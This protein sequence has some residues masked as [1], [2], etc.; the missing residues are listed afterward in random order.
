MVPTARL[1]DRYRLIERLGAG[2][3]SVV[4]RAYDEVL[5]RPVAVKMLNGRYAAD[6][7]SPKLIRAEARSAGRLSHPNVTNVYDYGEALET[8]GTRVPFVV[9]ELVDGVTLDAHLERGPL[10][11]KAAVRIAAEVAAALAA[12]HA[13]GLVHRDI[14]PANIMLTA[15]GVKVVDFGIAA[16]AGAHADNSPTVLGTPAYLAPERLL[17]SAVT[18]ASDVYALGLLLYRALTGRL[19]WLADTVT[20]MVNAHCYTEPAALPPIPDLPAEVGELCDRCLAKSPDDRPSAAEAAATLAAA[21]G[22]RVPLPLGEVLDWAGDESGTV[23]VAGGEGTIRTEPPVPEDETGYDAAGPRRSRS[24]VAAIALG[25]VMV[26]TAAGLATGAWS[27]FGGSASSGH[28]QPPA[29]AAEQLQ[30]GGA[31]TPCE[32]RYRTKSD[33][34]GAFAVDVTIVNGNQR[35]LPDWTLRF[36]FAGDQAVTGGTGAQWTQS[37][38]AVT[39]H[40][41]APLAAGATTTVSFTGG[42][43]AGNPLPTAFTLNGTSCRSVVTGAT[44][45][46]VQPAQPPQAG[47]PTQPAQQVASDQGNAAPGNGS[48]N[49]SDKGPGKGKAKGKGKGKG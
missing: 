11:G 16:V 33:V 23:A 22:V 35:T 21:A 26:V 17:G 1:V 28:G 40:G 9:M 20:Q 46:P 27:K 37:T 41:T 15:T 19:P 42:Y 12:A 32:V 13:H 30:V 3:M 2:G 45:E 44:G 8:D 47:Q 38:G 14:K 31:G 7:V 6:A 24:R 25:S 5:G 48:D 10:P 43:R 18:P 29:V 39:A 34:A 4:W 36:D 49:G